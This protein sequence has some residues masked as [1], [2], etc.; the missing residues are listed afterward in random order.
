LK[1]K[2]FVDNNDDDDDAIVVVVVVVVVVNC[3]RR[4]RILCVRCRSWHSGDDESSANPRE[5]AVLE[6][7]RQVRQRSRPTAT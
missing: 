6:D 5:Q 3:C 4:C 1:H 2:Y 7:S